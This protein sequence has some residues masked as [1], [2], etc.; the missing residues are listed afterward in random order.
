MN[1]KVS[2]NDYIKRRL[3]WQIQRKNNQKEVRTY[4]EELNEKSDLILAQILKIEQEQLKLQI[5]NKKYLKEK[6]SKLQVFL[7][8]MK[9]LDLKNIF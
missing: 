7:L 2:Q 8:Q 4:E 5:V 6:Y 9:I 3:K 1:Y